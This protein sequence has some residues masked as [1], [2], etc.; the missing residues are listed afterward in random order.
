MTPDDVLVRIINH[1]LFLE[2]A[3]Y[4]K[5]LSKGIVSTKKDNIAL[6]E[7]KNTKKKQVLVESSSEVEQDDDDDEDEE[8]E[9]DEEEM[10]LFIKKFN[11]Y[12]SKRRPF[13]GDK[14]EKPR[15]KRVCYNCGK[16]EHFIAQCP[17]ERKDEDD[18]KKKKKDKSYKKDKKFLKK[19]SYGQAHID[20]EWN[21]SD[22]RSESRSD[23]L[24][25]IAINGESSTRKSLFPNLFKHTCL[26]TKE[27]KNKVK[28]NA[29]SSSKY[30]SSDNDEPLPSECCK[31]PNAMI[32]EFMKQVRVRDEPLEQQQELLVE[33]KKSNE[34]LKK[35]LALE[36]GEIEKLDQELAQSK[37][38]TSSLKSSI[39]ALRDQYYVLQKTHQDLE[40]Q[41]DALWS[42]TSKTSSDPEAPKAYISKGCKRCYNVDLNTLCNQGQPPKVE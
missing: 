29:S 38:T 37:K 19:K 4:V 14:K 20:Q 5:N 26:M 2:E 10:T 31:N 9:Y 12:I 39:G 15:S 16:N 21:P 35:L 22:E 30:V 11:K 13:K 8:K 32:K 27:D 7:S 42:S 3:K 18:D 41:F 23:D 17:Y 28:T 25:T 6:K 33:E 24:A 40:V 36:K 1:E 34:K